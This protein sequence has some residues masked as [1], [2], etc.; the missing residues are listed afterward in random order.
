MNCMK[1]Q[2]ASSLNTM[3]FTGNCTYTVIQKW[4]KKCNIKSAHKWFEIN[5]QN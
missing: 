5:L 4:D 1:W 2:I 3:N